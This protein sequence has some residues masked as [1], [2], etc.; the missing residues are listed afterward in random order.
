MRLVWPEDERVSRHHF[1][2]AIFVTNGAV[3][4]N[5]QIQFPLCRVRVVRKIGFSRWHPV[6]FEVKRM[7]LGE[8]ERSRLASQRF[9]NSFEGDSEFAARRLPRLLFDFVEIY[10]AHFFVTSSKVEESL[11]HF[12]TERSRDVSTS[13]DTTIDYSSPSK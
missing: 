8:V 12:V 10:L 2:P 6:P 13:L 3:S 9:R 4:R 1:G 7:P 5:H 11:N